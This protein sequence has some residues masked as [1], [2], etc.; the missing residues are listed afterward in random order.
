VRHHDQ[1]RSARALQIEQ[2]VQDRGSVDAVEIAGRF[3]G[4]DQGR[5]VDDAARNGDALTLAAG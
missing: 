4:K 3:V 5:V 2:E 1:G